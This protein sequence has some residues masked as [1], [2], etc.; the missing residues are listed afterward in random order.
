MHHPQGYGGRGLDGLETLL[1][2]LTSQRGSVRSGE[3]T[4][5]SARSGTGW[6]ARLSP[7]RRQG[8]STAR[9]A[10]EAI[11]RMAEGGMMGPPLGRW[12]GEWWES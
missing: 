3:G 2:P 9:D 5:L 6:V 10:A 8:L 4:G 11:G 12:D 7:T 1:N